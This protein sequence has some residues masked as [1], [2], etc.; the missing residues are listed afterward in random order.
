[1]RRMKKVAAEMILRIIDQMKS[2]TVQYQE[3]PAAESS[4]FSFPKREDVKAFKK[5]GKKLL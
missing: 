5:R 2:G 3:N 4:Y 1:M